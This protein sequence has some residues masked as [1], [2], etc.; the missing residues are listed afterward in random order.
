MCEALL[1]LSSMFCGLHSKAITLDIRL[2]IAFPF[3]NLLCSKQGLIS[4]LII[5]AGR[6][7]SCWQ[8]VNLLHLVNTTY[9]KFIK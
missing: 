4:S 1:L 9:T 6:F 8:I 5:G 2:E 3:Y 7:L